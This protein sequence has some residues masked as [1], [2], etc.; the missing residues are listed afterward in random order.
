MNDIMATKELMHT[1]N[2]DC[3]INNDEEM[4]TIQSE[5]QVSNRIGGI[6]KAYTLMYNGV[7]MTDQ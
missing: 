5:P 3:N 2:S 7:L 1:I 4:M 6:Y